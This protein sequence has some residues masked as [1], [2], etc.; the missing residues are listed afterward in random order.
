L[1]ITQASALLAGRYVRINHEP[2]PGQRAL[3]EMSTVDSSM[4]GTLLT[5][6]EHAVNSAMQRDPTVLTRLLR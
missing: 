2:E 3:S 4:T 5:L 6:A 1:A